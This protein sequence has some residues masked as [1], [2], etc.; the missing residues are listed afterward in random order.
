MLRISA[1]LLPINNQ[2]N[3]GGVQNNAM[4]IP[5]SSQQGNSLLWQQLMQVLGGDLFQAMYSNAQ[6]FNQLCMLETE[7]GLYGASLITARGEIF[8]LL[9]FSVLF[10]SYFCPVLCPVLS[11]PVLFCSV[12]SC[13]VSCPVLFCPVLSCSVL[14]CPVLSFF[15]LK[16]QIKYTKELYI[17]N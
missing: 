6:D 14:S 7:V 1:L 11:C 10:C 17:G 16:I 9:F 3:N 2:Q 12:L 13:S 8:V 15:S 4:A 5:Q